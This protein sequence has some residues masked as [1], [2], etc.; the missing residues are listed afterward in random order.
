LIARWPDGFVCPGCGGR[1]AGQATRRHLWVCTGCKLQTSVTAGTVMH[2]TRTPLRTWFW[3]AYLVATHHPGI[4]AKQLQRQLDL[5]RYETA[6]LILHKLRRAMIAPERS[7]LLEEVEVDEF[8]FGGLEEGLKGGRQRGKKA[9]RRRRGGPQARLLAPAPG[10]SARRERRLAD[11]VRDLHHDDQ[12][13]RAHRR[14]AELQAPGQARLRAP[15]ALPARGR[16]RRATAAPRAPRRLQPEDVDARHPPRRQRRA[17]RRL[18]RRVRASDTT[19]AAPR[20][21][22]TMAA[23]QTLLGLGTQQAP[24]T[25]DQITRSAA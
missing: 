22:S 15:P 12:R 3:A 20:W 2:A 18:P 23:F 14:L 13:G 6:W 17:P 8:F 11:S 4:S 7:L 1:R 5:S 9:R 24:A 10:R 16:A 19:A 21:N 25:F